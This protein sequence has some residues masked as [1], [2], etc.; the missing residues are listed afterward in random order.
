MALAAA[1]ASLHFY[2]LGLKLNCF[3]ETVVPGKRAIFND[4]IDWYDSKH[5][6]S[7]TRIDN[8]TQARVNTSPRRLCPSARVCANWWC[9]IIGSNSGQLW[10]CYFKSKWKHPPELK[11]FCHSSGRLRELLALHLMYFPLQYTDHTTD[12]THTDSNPDL[13]WRGKV[14]M[15]S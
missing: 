9:A 7:D 15:K 1:W 12:F 5:T 3:P 10:K 8:T 4:R 6:R 13:G 14:G 2:R 11:T